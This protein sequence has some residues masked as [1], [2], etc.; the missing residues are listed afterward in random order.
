MFSKQV[1]LAGTQYLAVN[2]TVCIK[3]PTPLD[4]SGWGIDVV[5][6]ILSVGG[7]DHSLSAFLQSVLTVQRPV[8]KR[9]VSIQ[10]VR[11][12]ATVMEES[13]TFQ[14]TYR[15]PGNHPGEVLAD[16]GD[17]AVFLIRQSKSD[18]EFVWSMEAHKT[19]DSVK[20]RLTWNLQ[21]KPVGPHPGSI[22]VDKNFIALYVNAFQKRM[23]IRE[24]ALSRVGIKE[25]NHTKGRT[26]QNQTTI[27]TAPE[28]SSSNTLPTFEEAALEFKKRN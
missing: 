9:V 23:D 22:P 27:P 16:E 8:L 26:N 25:K 6:F 4:Y 20:M 18:R 28:R 10:T 1:A 2:N 5:D 24:R 11:G 7:Y 21:C 14:G 3:S 15:V 13:H 19:K 12:A 17:L